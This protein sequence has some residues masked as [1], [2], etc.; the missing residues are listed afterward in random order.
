MFLA[1]GLA[2]PHSEAVPLYSIV[3][4]VVLITFSA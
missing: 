2:P 3:S 4:G 1:I